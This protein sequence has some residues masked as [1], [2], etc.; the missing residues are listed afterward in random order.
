MQSK[1]TRQPCRQVATV[2]GFGFGVLTVLGI[3]GFRGFR[4]FRF[5]VYGLG[6]WELGTK[7]VE[8]FGV[9]GVRG[10]G[11]RVVYLVST[12]GASRL[13]GSFPDSV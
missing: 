6:L 5:V 1:R 10:L 4:G 2:E 11:F 12:A 8:G 3:W 7:G 13:N 9:S